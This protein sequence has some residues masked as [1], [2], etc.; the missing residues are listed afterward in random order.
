MLTVPWKHL[1]MDFMLG[2]L[3]TKQGNDSIF[4]VVNR[5]SNMMHFIPCWKPSD[6]TG[7]VVLFFK[8]IMRLHGLPKRITSYRDTKFLGNFWRTLWKKIGMKLQFFSRY[9]PQI[10]RKNKS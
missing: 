10:N 2:L 5:F 3:K 9:H 4:V 7:I 8:D 1:S 6:A